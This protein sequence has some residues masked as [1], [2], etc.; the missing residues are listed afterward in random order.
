MIDF[1]KADKINFFNIIIKSDENVRSKVSFIVQN[2]LF[3]FRNSKLQ[4]I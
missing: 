2:I 4:N 3:L 1:D